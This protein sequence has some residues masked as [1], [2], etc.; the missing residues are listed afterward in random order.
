MALPAAA[1]LSYT[2]GVMYSVTDSLP[3]LE[4][5]QSKFYPVSSKFHSPYIKMLF[6][7]DLTFL[8]SNQVIRFLSWREKTS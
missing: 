4:I 7:E 1:S 3:A 8:N 5:D 6:K 2:T